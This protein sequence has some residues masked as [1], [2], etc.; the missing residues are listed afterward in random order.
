MKLNKKV[1]SF[2][3]SMML[4]ISVFLLPATGSENEEKQNRVFTSSWSQLTT[5]DSGF[6]S[7]FTF[8]PRGDGYIMMS[9]CFDT[10][11]WPDENGEFIGLLADSWESSADGI[12]WT[13]YLRENVT[14]HDGEP[15]TANDVVFTINYMK[16]KAHVSPVGSSWYN[17][18]IIDNVKAPDDHTV[19]IT[20]KQPYAPFMQLVLDVIPIMP[21]HIWKDVSDPSTYM[22]E[23]AVVGTG[24]F[25][26]EDYDKEQ[27]SYKYSANKDY[28]L[29]EPVIDTLIYVQT[30]DPILSLKTGEVDESSLSF[31]QVQALSDQ[32]NLKVISG[33]GYHVYRLRFNIPSNAI[34]NDTDVRKAIYYSL[35]CEDI[36]SRVLHGGGVVGNPGYVPPYSKW[37]YPGVTKYAYDP[38]KANQMLDDAGYQ[39]KDTDGIRIDPDGNRLEFQLLY[40]TEQQSQRLAEL[41]QTYFKEVGIGIILKPGDRMTVDG[42]VGS[43]NFEMAIYT[44]ATATEPGNMLNSFPTSTGWNN[45][46]FMS[47][48]TEQMVTMDEEKRKELVD[49]MQVLIADNVPTIPVFYR[50]MYS[51]CNQEKFDG[52]FYTPEGIAGGIPVEYNKLAFIYGNWNGESTEATEDTSTNSADSIGIFGS[53]AVLA[54]AFLLR[55]YSQS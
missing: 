14:W 24:P 35:D 43:G 50:D 5:A 32:D 51:A 39:N 31:D 4:I 28:F 21:E 26:L 9:Y 6:P 47:L 38:E 12:E 3:L 15:F 10:L 53:V 1:I 54:S 46:E 11:I 22:E 17:T 37:Y 7:P 40:P 41:I 48:A 30:S 13:F 25:I 29:G 2:F 19:I 23:D 34:L 8:Y 36:M 33:P 16:E 52:F 20:L 44:H 18:A 49:R 27:K 45:S 55:K 42:L